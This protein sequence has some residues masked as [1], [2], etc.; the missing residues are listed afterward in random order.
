[1]HTWWGTPTSVSVN[2]DAGYFRTTGTPGTG[3][4][5][6]TIYT[7]DYVGSASVS[8][9]LIFSAGGVNGRMLLFKKI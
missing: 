6:K 7:G 1:M 3:R 5:E 9:V 4:M 8:S 2:G